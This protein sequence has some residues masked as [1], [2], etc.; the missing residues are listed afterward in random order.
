V[1]FCLANIYKGISSIFTG[2]YPQY[3]IGIQFFISIKSIN[4]GFLLLE[5]LFRKGR[6]IIGTVG[7]LYLSTVPLV[8]VITLIYN[9]SKQPLRCLFQCSSLFRIIIGSLSII[10]SFHHVDRKQ[11]IPI[12][13]KEDSFYTIYFYPRLR[14]SFWVKLYHLYFVRR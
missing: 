7:I 8:L 9:L 5:T 13:V 10:N 12:T 6:Y 2:I 14:I 3:I 1:D 4:V 11:S